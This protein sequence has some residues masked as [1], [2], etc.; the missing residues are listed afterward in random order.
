MPTPLA[1]AMS[2]NAVRAVESHLHGAAHDHREC[3]VVIIDAEGTVRYVSP[4]F[5]FLCGY[6]RYEILGKSVR[7][8]LS[9][10]RDAVF[11]EALR[12]ALRNGKAWTGT[13]AATRPDGPPRVESATV[14]PVT[15]ASGA[16][17]QCVGVRRDVT[18]D[19]L[20]EDAAHKSRTMEA[21]ARLAGGMAHN[22]NNLLTSI[23]GFSE[24][25][26]DR[27]TGDAVTT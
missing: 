14:C 17:T 16:V 15:D 20:R 2:R 23:I 10:R 19:A 26:L 8:L 18:V 22:F 25:L 5:E 21:V 6:S 11:F 24:L 4:N 3:A 7:D 13:F 1:V 9:G 12:D 27:M